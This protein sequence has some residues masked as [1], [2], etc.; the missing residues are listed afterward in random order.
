M[1]SSSP[2]SAEVIRILNAEVEIHLQDRA[3]ARFALGPDSAWSGAGSATAGPVV[4]VA[5]GMV[6]V[7]TPLQNSGNAQNWIW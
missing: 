3:A 6:T 2:N 7:A 5:N 1:R 4:S